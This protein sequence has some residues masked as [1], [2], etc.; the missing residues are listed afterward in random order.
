MRFGGHET[1]PVREGWLHKGLKLVVEEPEKV[2]DEH[3][4][5]WLGVGRNMAKSIRY[6]LQATGLCEQVSGRRHRKGAPGSDDSPSSG[7]LMRDLKGL[8]AA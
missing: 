8:H 7:G 3:V 2:V 6:W 4:A 1:F 5:D